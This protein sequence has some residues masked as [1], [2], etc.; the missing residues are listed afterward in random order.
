[1][2][3]VTL[4]LHLRNGVTGAVRKG[5]TLTARFVVGRRSLLQVLY[6]DASHWLGPQERPSS[7]N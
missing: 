3:P 1:M 4:N 5:M 7:Q 2:Q 6:E